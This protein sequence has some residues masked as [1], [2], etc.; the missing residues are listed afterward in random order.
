[1]SVIVPVYFDYASALC[2]IAWRMSARLQAELDVIMRW[3][4]VHIAAQYPSWKQGGLIGGDAREKIERVSHE[5]GVPLRIPARWL[6]SRPALEGAVFAEEHRRLSDY[7]DA[8]FTAAYEHGDNIGDR[9][10]LVRAADAAGLPMGRFM[11]WVA[12]RRAGP[13]LAATLEEARE[14]GVVG[15]PTFLLGEF[16]LTGIH[17]YDTMKLLVARHI[18]R[19]RDRLQ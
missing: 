17:P 6:D 15:Y 10:V 7:H 18:E 4:P 9:R 3:R 2:F 16:P 1:M 13:Q 8:V 5:T 12:T 14:H 19:C 11:E